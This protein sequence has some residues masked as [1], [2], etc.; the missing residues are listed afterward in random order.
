MRI[1]SLVECI[2]DIPW[3]SFETGKNP[4]NRPIKGN[5]YHVCDIGVSYG[6]SWIELSEIQP[7]NGRRRLWEAKVFVE[8][9][10]PM[11]IQL[12]ELISEPQII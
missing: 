4:E 8:L 9:Q 1:G 11:T 10:P 5:I 7:H 2:K 12:E 3:E 6:V